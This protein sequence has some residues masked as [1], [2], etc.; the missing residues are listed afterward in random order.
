MNDLLPSDEIL[1]AYVD[2]ELSPH[3]RAQ[4]AQAVAANAYLADRVAVLAQLKATVTK[5]GVQQPIRLGDLRVSVRPC[6]PFKV[7]AASIVAATLV[8]GVIVASIWSS[9]ISPAPEWVAQSR[10]QHLAW[11]QD[12]RQISS[13][14]DFAT[15]LRAKLQ[16]LEIQQYL[17]DLSSTNLKLSDIAYFDDAGSNGPSAVQVRYTGQHG[18]RVSLTFS[19]GEKP[20]KIALTETDD[21]TS[22]GYFW[23]VGTINF[24]LFST[25][26]DDRRFSLI[27][28]NVYEATRDKR[29]PPQEHEKELRIATNSAEPCKA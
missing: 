21:G 11:L 2:G 29:T 10:S 14:E 28:R 3:D 17:P 15:L 19:R 20:L 1:N 7:I 22:R 16:R 18:C 6:R 13:D 4:V 23:R 9:F 8:T 25:G 12:Q 27:A 24:A 26:M 5:L